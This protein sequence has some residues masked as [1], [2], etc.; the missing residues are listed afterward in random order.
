MRHI[1]L[2]IM[3]VMLLFSMD[4]SLAASPY[5]AGYRVGLDGYD[6]PTIS[7]DEYWSASLFADLMPTS[8]FSPSV[9]VGFLLPPYPFEEAAYATAGASIPL[10]YWLG[11]PLRSLFRR[12]SAYA[13]VFGVQAL[14]DLGHIRL[15]GGSAILHPLR[16]DF[17][18]K[19][20]GI[21]SFQLV[22]DT[23]AD[24][25]GWGLRIFEISHYLW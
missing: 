24:Q 25:W 13:P 21:L 2:A 15:G 7:T 17:G 4:F 9:H 19:Q 23:V 12:D 14:F 11:H 22:Y 6:V 5:V 16:F 20:V 18:D 10:A 8:R 1:K 3:A